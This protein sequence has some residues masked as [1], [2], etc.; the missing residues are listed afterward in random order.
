MDAALQRHD[1]IISREI[2]RYH[3]V[4]AK[5]TG[6]GVL[7]LFERPS[8]AVAFTVAAQLALQAE[9]WP[10]APLRV[11]MGVHTGEVR[12]R[13]GDVFGPDVNLAARIENAAHGGQILV[14]ASTEPLI[15]GAL[16]PFT[17]IID[18]GHWMLRNVHAPQHLFEVRHSSLRSRFLRPR[19]SRPGRSS[20]PVLSSTYVDML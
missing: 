1:A 13:D 5:H 7:A 18:L 8:E 11:R 14:S 3:G 17:T 16:P 19:A 4:I 9:E 20:L 10:G 2:E 6:D 15:R 12:R